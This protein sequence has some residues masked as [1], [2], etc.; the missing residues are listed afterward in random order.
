MFKVYAT[1]PGRR[2]RR[3]FVALKPYELRTTEETVE[4]CLDLFRKGYIIHKVV[5][6]SGML[7]TGAAME[8]ALKIGINS[9]RAALQR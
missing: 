9:V 3:T 4:Y 1:R 7:I 5:V 6:P 8:S 2:A